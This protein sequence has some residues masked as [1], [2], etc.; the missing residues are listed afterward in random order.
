[1]NIGQLIDTMKS[2]NLQRLDDTR[3]LIRVVLEGFMPETKRKR[4]TWNK[5]Y[6][7]ELGLKYIQTVNE[8]RTEK[9]LKKA[10]PGR[11]N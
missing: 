4:T 1:M 7:T 9:S 11:K 2:R 3:G 10:I 6:I 8:D 5:L